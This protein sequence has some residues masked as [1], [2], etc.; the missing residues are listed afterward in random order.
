MW[1]ELTQLANGE[2]V[3]INMDLAQYYTKIT[4]HPGTII[5]FQP[6]TRAEVN[7]IFVVETMAYITQRLAEMTAGEDTDDDTPWSGS[8]GDD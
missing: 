5:S 7:R 2:K 4:D 8:L 6:T 1:I 3:W